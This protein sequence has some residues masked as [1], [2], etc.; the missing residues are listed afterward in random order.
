[1]R[2]LLVG[3]TGFIGPYVAKELEDRGHHVTLFHR[4]QHESPLL[5][6][7]QHFRSAEAAIPVLHFPASSGVIYPASTESA[8]DGIDCEFCTLGMQ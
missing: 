1:M 7:I 2:I 4:G 5:S 3:G 6:S 8:L